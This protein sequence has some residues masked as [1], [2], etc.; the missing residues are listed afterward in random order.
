MMRF[1]LI[2]LGAA[3]GANARYWI[4][5]WAG[6]RLG[7]DFPYGTFLVNVTGCFLIGL[8]FGLGET[9]FTISSELRLLFVVGFLGSYTTFSSFGYESI[10]LLRSSTLL[11][12][13][14][15]LLLTL[16]LGLP[17]VVL[18]LQVARWLT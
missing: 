9:R 13:G 11:L 3:L 15:N 17:A 6:S 14:L 18:G 5:V 2:A 4:G 8:F 16:A 7:V 10:M 1:L 12:A